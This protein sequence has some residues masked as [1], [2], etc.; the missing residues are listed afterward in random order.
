VKAEPTATVGGDDTRRTTARSP[1]VAV[2]ARKLDRRLWEGVDR[3]VDRAPSLGDLRAHQLE[4]LALAR[5]RARGRPIP[6]T[7]VAEGHAAAVKALAAPLL[8][9]RV[10][11]ACDG[12][13]VLLKGPET[14]ACYPHPSAR[15]FVDLDVLVPDAHAVQRGLLGAGFNL[16]GE[17]RRYQGAHHLQPLHYPGS[18]LVVEVH[19]RPKWLTELRPPPIDELFAAA[20]MSVVPVAGISALPPAHHAVLLAA[21]GWAHEP[22]GILRHLIDVAAARQGA[23]A[24]EAAALASAWGIERIWNMTTATID[25]LLFGAQRPWALRHWAR[26]LG[27]VRE[28]TVLEAHLERWLAGFSAFPLWS[29]AR[30]AVRAIRAD[31]RP[32][33][34]EDWST[35]L[36]RIRTAIRD[37]FVRRSQ[38]DARLNS[39]FVEGGVAEVV[40]SEG[41]CVEWNRG[42]RG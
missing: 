28:R 7:L 38:H 32:A 25:A 17:E 20:V 31:V 11:E 5:W 35:K 6:R 42:S 24:S 8:L 10:R 41:R 3:L 26:N 39:A 36:R 21:H 22:L 14:A 37:A 18:P 4:L 19:I 16:I 12:P 33:S 27:G 29:A 34:N 30:M 23:S 40:A 15:S 2:A 13:I 9:Q 1:I